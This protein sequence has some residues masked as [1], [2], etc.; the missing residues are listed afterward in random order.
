MLQYQLDLKEQSQTRATVPNGLQQ[1]L[2]FWLEHCGRFFT[3]DQYFTKRDG[4]ENYLLLVT[5]DGCGELTYQG[6][7][8]L[9]KRGTAVVI[10]CR[11]YHQYRT[12]TGRTWDFYYLHFQ[13]LSFDGYGFL[14]QQLTPVSLPDLY[15]ACT[16]LEELYDLSQRQDRYAYYMESH[17]ISCLLTE[18]VTALQ[19]NQ[20][21]PPLRQDIKRLAEYIRGHSNQ[22]LTIDQLMNYSKLSRYYLIHAF[23]QQMGVSPMGYLH[24]CRIRQAEMLLTTTHRT[25]DQ[26]AAQVGYASATVLIRHFKQIHHLTPTAYRNRQEKEA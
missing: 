10:D 11:Y 8:C 3:A 7:T 17:R 12:V 13:S 5:T 14:T 9:L 25:V 6:E 16:H 19:K 23:T 21:D 2:P 4:L 18:M 24:R 22:P 20:G 1:Q 26:I 15:T